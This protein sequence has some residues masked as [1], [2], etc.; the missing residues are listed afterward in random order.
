MKNLIFILSACIVLLAVSC[1]KNNELAPVNAATPV[2]AATVKGTASTDK[3]TTTLYFAG[4]D[5][6]N[7]VYWQDGTEHNLSISDT[8]DN[9]SRS[10]R[11][12][13]YN[14][15]VAGT[16]VYITGHNG[17]NYVYWK[18]GTANIMPFS[19]YAQGVAVS[20]TDVYFAGTSFR[21]TPEYLYN[22][23]LLKNGTYTAVSHAGRSGY[24]TG[25][26]I[27]GTDVYYT[28][29]DN[30]PN[31]TTTTVPVY[32]KNG[33]E[34]F[35]PVV[36]SPG[37]GSV[38]AM[39]VSGTDVYIAGQDGQEAVYW[40][41]GVEHVLPMN[42]Y[43]GAVTAMAVSGTDVYFA[44]T[45]FRSAVY[46]KNGV[47]TTLPLSNGGSAY[48]FVTGMAAGGSDI[49]IAGWEMSGNPVTNDNYDT[50][51]YWKNGTVHTLPVTSAGGA[52]VTA[53][54]IAGR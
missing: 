12:Y 11:G 46:W 37:S 42:G 23:A 34:H 16:D 50:P 1:K 8:D 51:E 10:V 9:G 32:W 48:S 13:T 15:A 22:L 49:Y 5:G 27:A 4:L 2:S 47:E 40:K 7:P 25:T 41:N 31:T 26:V 29:S 19:L 44:G 38:Y 43:V 52:S 35:L 14:M 54:A 53:M 24:I 21:D 30:P 17:L 3:R 28:G 18:N 45:D 20:G 6:T 33:V 36:S 39:S